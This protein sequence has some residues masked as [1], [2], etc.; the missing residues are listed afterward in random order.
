[1][2]VVGK[3]TGSFTNDKGELISFGQ[4]HCLSDFEDSNFNVEGQ[5]VIVVKLK[6]DEV[7]SISL[8]SEIEVVY[9]RYGR[10]QRV[11]VL[12]TP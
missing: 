9:N 11:D 7:A 3:K 6:P 8:G 2:K 1:M 5:E 10:V 4:L 12:S